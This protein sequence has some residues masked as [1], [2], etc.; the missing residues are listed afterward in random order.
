M[1]GVIALFDEKSEQFIKDIWR[2]LR[3]LGISNYAYEV[4]D[5]RPHLTLAS[6]TNLDLEA[7][8][9]KMNR[10]YENQRVLPVTFSSI[11]SFIGSGTLFF[12]PT[13]TK[14]LMDFHLQYHLQ[15]EG[16]T[17]DPD[18]IYL[19][20]KWIPHCTIANRLSPR[21]LSEAF[22]FCSYKGEAFSAF[23][24]EVA[25]IDASQKNKAPILYSIELR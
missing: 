6:Y 5:R 13:I 12:S 9:K 4:E 18:S 3:D 16:F 21:K 20:D 7:F 22:H 8:K 17:N 24:Q 25:L 1:Y 10:V 14:N 23:I 2:N 15:L 19:P 11:G